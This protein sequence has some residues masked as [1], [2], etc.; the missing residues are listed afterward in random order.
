MTSAAAG[1]P[2]PERAH[3][4]WLL[5]ALRVDT[6]VYD[7]IA[8][9]P[10]PRLDAGMRRLTRASD[11]S[12]LWFGCAAILGTTRG[13]SGRRAAARGL[14]SVAVASAVANLVIKPL[15]RRRRPDSSALLASRPGAG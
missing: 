13:S 10:T 9:T 3:P 6:A 12:R 15:T 1:G 5:E 8:E 11:Y 14:A 2:A 7:A 4:D